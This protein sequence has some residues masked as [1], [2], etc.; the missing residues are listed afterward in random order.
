MT[1][2]DPIY[3]EL[4]SRLQGGSSKYL[5]K[6][7]SILVNL[8]EAKILQ[9]LPDPDRDPDAGRSLSVSDKFAEKLGMEKTTVDSHLQ[10]LFE[11]GVIFP[12]SKGPQSAR[13]MGQLR[14]ACTGNPKYDDLVGNEF[15][16]LWSAWDEETWPNVVKRVA[17]QG[18]STQWRIVPRWEA[19][20]DIPGILPFEDARE[21]FRVHQDLLALVNCCCKRVERDRPCGTP[22][23]VCI[24]V[25]RT[26][27]Y[28]ID[29]GTGKKITYDEA[30]G[31]IERT[32][33]YPTVHMTINLKNISQ[34]FCNCHSCC[35][36]VLR[37]Y[38]EVDELKPQQAV[39]PS[40]FVSEIDP[41]ECNGCRICID[42]RCMFGAVKM[43]Y[44]PEIG[45][46]RAYIDPEKC[47]GCGNCVISCPTEAITM[48][49]VRPADH[50]P[51]TMK[52]IYDAA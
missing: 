13:S 35:C 1:E 42:D 11:K 51:D 37:P 20:K 4:A 33:E 31:V 44:F 14:D 49:I 9:A 50:V 39:S 43:K 12:T 32:R 10:E 40:R 19:I 8:D 18:G 23:D 24:N 29:K 2:L 30:L 5:P 22:E 6:I 17:E 45:E 34:L 26:A 47:M 16:D 38:W 21:I 7:L 28:N 48:K 27:Q 25:G 36:P 15:F 46:K 3:Q 52:S 41:E